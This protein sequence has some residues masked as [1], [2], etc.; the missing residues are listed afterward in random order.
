VKSQV[1]EESHWGDKIKA[2]RHYL[3]LSRAALGKELRVSAETVAQWERSSEKPPPNTCI[4]LGNLAGEPSCW[5]FWKLAGLY[6]GDFV[7]ALPA[8]RLH[9]GKDDRPDL[10]V[11]HAGSGQR[12][13]SKP[14]LHAIPLLP[15]KAGTVGQVGDNDIEFDRMPAEG[16]IAAPSHWAPNPAFTSCLRVRGDSMAPVICDGYIIAVDT[17]MTE[18]EK[19]M[20]KVVVAWHQEKGLTVSWLKM[21]VGGAALA[22]QNAEYGSIALGPDT[23]WRVIAKVLWW[24]GRDG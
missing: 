2:L 14:Q 24:I 3:K 19:L 22:S 16:L 23:G 10:Q 13:F 21:L 4:G 8:V 11:V 18:V 1:P 20:D 15:L 5:E 7:H 12:L 17:S 9:M 6:S